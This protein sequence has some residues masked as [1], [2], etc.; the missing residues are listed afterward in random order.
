M[1]FSG[2]HYLMFKYLEVSMDLSL[3]P[4]VNLLFY[5]M[6]LVWFVLNLLKCFMVQYIVYLG[7]ISV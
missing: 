2:V 7:G 3:I 6:V 5:E 1:F 4:M